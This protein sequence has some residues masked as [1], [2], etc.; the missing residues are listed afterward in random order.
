MGTHFSLLT[1]ACWFRVPVHI[2]QYSLL[3]HSLAEAH[4]TVAP[5]KSLKVFFLLKKLYLFV[6]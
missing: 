2:A 4:F 3:P 6:K 1:L 5:K